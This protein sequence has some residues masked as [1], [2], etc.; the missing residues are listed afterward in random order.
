MSRELND[1]IVVA[2]FLVHRLPSPRGPLGLA[3]CILQAPTVLPLP[4]R[5]HA[6]RM[7]LSPVSYLDCVVFC[8]LLAPQLVW[9]AGLLSTVA[10]ALAA[11][12]F[13]VS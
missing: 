8:A 11:L 2:S 7:L 4:T 3:A 13:C 5:T 12:R 10:T 6:Y 9:R 1:W